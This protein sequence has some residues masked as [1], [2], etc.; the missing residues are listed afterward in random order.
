MRT[1]LK[2]GKIYVEKNNFQEAIYIENGMIKQVGTNEDILKNYSDNI[3]DL[4]GKTVLPGFN[5][6]HM[7]LA[8][9]GAAMTSCN[10]TTAKSIAEIIQLGKNFLEENEGLTVLYGRGWNQDYFITG[11]KRLLNRLDLD[12]ISMEIPIVFD[13][14]CGHVSV[15]NTK[16]L[17]VLGVDGNTVIDG[18]TIELD[19]EGNPNGIF[20]ENAIRL[21]QSVIPEK[22]DKDREEE[23]LK[24]ANYALSVGITSIQSCD[25]TGKES[26]NMFNIIHNIYNNQKTKLRYSHQFNFQD[27]DD[28][29]YYLETEYKTGQYDEKFLSKGA[30]K[31]FKDGS[32]GARTAL[33]LKDY[34]DAPSTKGV[35]ALTDEQLQEL[36]NLATEHKIRV[37]THAIGD[38]AVESLINAYEKT[39]KDGKNNLRHG[40]VH[41]QITSMEQLERIA[42][43]DIPVMYQPIFL[44]YDLKI[45]EARVGKELSSTSY[46][47]NTLYQ[48]GAPISFGTDSPVEDCNPFPNIY[49]AVTRQGIDGNPIGGFYPKEKME[50]QDVIDVYTIGSAFNEF[51]EDFKG[52]LKP[53]YVA[54][55]IVLD[56]DIFTIEESKIKDIKVEKTMIDGELVYER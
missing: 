1:I 39:M 7:H 24:A 41:C 11:E 37:V 17:E 51:K 44:D 10:L 42:R 46:A 54:D 9:I 30:L 16:A 38:G 27:I 45:V 22:D 3:I 48:L 31:L 20:N 25:I 52:R 47:F 12:K 23:F 28:L 19:S 33:M 18:G 34:E 2:N 14:I 53:G 29:K 43:L 5:D 13:R 50:L 36:C 4:Q 26:Q 21:I 6:S 56:M 32:L 40:I 35:S 55:L 15:G 49:C 8:S